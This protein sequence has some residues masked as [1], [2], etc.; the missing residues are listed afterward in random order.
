MFQRSMV[1]TLNR[2]QPTQQSFPSY[3][4]GK[5]KCVHRLVR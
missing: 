4:K 3:L 2:N 1:K 5:R